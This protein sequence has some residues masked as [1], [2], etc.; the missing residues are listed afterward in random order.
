MKKKAERVKNVYLVKEAR[1]SRMMREKESKKAVTFKEDGRQSNALLQKNRVRNSLFKNNEKQKA[2]NSHFFSDH[3]KSD[4]SF[5]IKSKNKLVRMSQGYNPNFPNI[6]DLNNSVLF[7]IR[8]SKF[9]PKIII[10]KTLFSPRAKKSAKSVWG[11]KVKSDN[12]LNRESNKEF[13]S[14]YRELNKESSLSEIKQ[15][16][17]KYTI[18]KHSVLKQTISKHSI[19]K[20]TIMKHSV[21]KQINNI[22]LTKTDLIQEHYQNLLNTNLLNKDRAQEFTIANFTDLLQNNIQYDKVNIDLVSKYFI[23]MVNEVNILNKEITQFDR[24][25]RNFHFFNSC[26]KEM[27]NSVITNID[28]IE[29][30][31]NKI[32]RNNDK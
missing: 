23:Y 1:G 6:K 27:L 32:E 22:N 2:R 16:I 11:N 14:F 3:N 19:L 4:E 12:K 25:I 30:E 18:S 28:H 15:S 5:D 21:I 10:D 8:T 31:Q 26:N 9:A 7:K 29:I 13:S 24:I 17:L 20:Q